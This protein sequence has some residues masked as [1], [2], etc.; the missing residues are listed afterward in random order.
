MLEITCAT[1]GPMV[2]NQQR[3]VTI[4][5]IGHLGNE[6]QFDENEELQCSAT[7]ARRRPGYTKLHLRTEP[8]KA[9]FAHKNFHNG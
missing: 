9:L 3:M 2:S 1:T 7:Y 6:L 4:Y 5:K 8:S